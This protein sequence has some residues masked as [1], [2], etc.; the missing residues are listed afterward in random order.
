MSLQGETGLLSDVEVSES[1]C[2]FG[3]LL[4]KALAVSRSACRVMVSVDANGRLS[5]N[6]LWFVIFCYH[7]F[8]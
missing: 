6:V 1:E 2:R 4:A 5:Q 3:W 7:F 8:Q